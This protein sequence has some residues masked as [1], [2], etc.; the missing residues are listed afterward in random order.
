MTL[1]S[2]T[3]ERGGEG[4]RKGEREGAYD[5]DNDSDSDKDNDSDNDSNETG[6]GNRKK[7][8]CFCRRARFDEMWFDVAR[9]LGAARGEGAKCRTEMG[10]E[11]AAD[12]ES[13]KRCSKHMNYAG[14]S[15]G[16]VKDFK[17]RPGLLLP[18][19]KEFYHYF[20]SLTSP[21]CSEVVNWVVMKDPIKITPKQLH[22][23]HKL[24]SRREGVRIGKYGNTRPLQDI[25]N[26]AVLSTC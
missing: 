10:G 6:D 13:S 18:K 20:G 3:T 24:E 11:N 12:A 23:L 7:V 9:W 22:N 19:S 25:N 2:M 8:K 5:S 15:D 1:G 17:L 21:P 14:C 4:V 16:T 26:R